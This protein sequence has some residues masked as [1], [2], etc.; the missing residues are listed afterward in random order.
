MMLLFLGLFRVV[1][2]AAVL[3]VLYFWIQKSTGTWDQE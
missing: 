1:C 2:A 3:V